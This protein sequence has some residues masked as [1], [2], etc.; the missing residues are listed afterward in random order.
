[1]A[2]QK[3]TTEDKVLSFKKYH[4]KHKNKLV[5]ERW[6][7]EYDKLSTRELLE[8]LNYQHSLDFPFRNS[9]QTKDRL[10]HKALVHVLDLRAQSQFLKN[11]LK[12]IQIKDGIV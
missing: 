2:E 8:Y 4:Q 12:D 11:F 3:T 9:E 5:F 7:A 10:R 6:V 1:M